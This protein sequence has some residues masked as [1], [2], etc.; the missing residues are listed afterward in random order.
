LG[1][2][3]LMMGIHNH[4]PVGNFG[5]VMEE[6]F[7]MCYKPQMEVLKAHPLVRVAIHHSGPLLEWIEQNRPSY[8]DDLASLVE[9]KQVEI[10]SGGFY[11]PILT[12][13]PEDD[14]IGQIVM[15]NEYAEKRFGARPKGMWLAERIWD[16]SLP[17]ILAAAGIQFTLLDDTHFRYAGLGAREMFGYWV[18]EKHGKTV[19]VFPIDMNLRYAIPFKMPQDTIDYLNWASGEM[20]ACG[21]TYGDDGE[22]FGVWP[23]TH[24]WVFNKK[25]LENFY[26]LLENNTDR[27]RMSFFS[28]FIQNTPPMGRVYLPPASYEEMGEWSLDPQAQRN[29]HKTLTE[30]TDSGKKEEY[31]PFIRGGQWDNFLA[32]YDEANRMHK[33]MLY[34]SSALSSLDGASSTL[35]SARRS[36]YR[37]QCNC[38]Y[39]HGLFGG[40]YLNYLRHAIYSN[41]I[42]A[43]NEIDLALRGLG[44]WISVQTLDFDSDGQDEIVIKNPL[45][46]VG[47]Q[48]GSGGALFMLDYRPAAFCLTNTFTRRRE[49]Y[50]D[51]IIASVAGSGGH[52]EAPA[53]IHDI[54]RFKEEGLA[55][56]LVFDRRQRAIH[57][58]ELI[59]QQVTLEA[60]QRG[61]FEQ[62][63]DFAGKPWTVAQIPEGQGGETGIRLERLGIFYADGDARPLLISKTFRMNA[64][65]PG[66]RAAYRIENRSGSPISSKLALEFNMTMLAADADDRYWIGGSASGKRKLKETLSDTAA[67]SVG[68]R[69]DWAGFSVSVSSNTH[70]DA[71]RYPVETVSQSESGFERTYQGSCIVMLK[72]IDLPA[73]GA[74]EFDADIFMKAER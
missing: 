52:G 6:S 48:P 32:K 26:T 10:L 36:L 16:P 73:G 71:W 20:G 47:I 24:E 68:M 43:E 41:L 56:H 7:Q 21:V 28:E 18:T 8:L 27:I 40:L 34:V 29:Y 42:Q 37:G 46:T 55:D 58:L 63:G 2:V 64:T 30:I 25:W 35:D 49:A 38:A 72:Q 44:P 54:V 33:K 53:S 19:S 31:K 3:N 59:H 12:S 39:W 65:A 15:M 22:K 11:E 13:I 69:D 17:R 74:M 66:V 1:A 45:I 57:Q 61:D 51:K 50:H 70:F 5:H 14:A 67:V 9:K 4:Q 60:Y 23:E 62:L